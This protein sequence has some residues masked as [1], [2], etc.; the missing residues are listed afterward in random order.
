MWAVAPITKIFMFALS[1]SF[2]Q[3]LWMKPLQ[4]VF[5]S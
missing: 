3:V 2:G 4:L 1:A 5:L